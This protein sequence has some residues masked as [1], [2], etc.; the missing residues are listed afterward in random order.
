MSLFHIMQ[1]DLLLSNSQ[2]H[3]NQ[4]LFC[5]YHLHHCRNLL[6]HLATFYV[7]FIILILLKCTFQWFKKKLLL[8]LSAIRTTLLSIVHKMSRNR[9]PMN[10]NNSLLVLTR[11]ICWTWKG[12]TYLPKISRYHLSLSAKILQKSTII[13]FYHFSTRCLHERHYLPKISRYYLG[14]FSFLNGPTPASFCLFS[15]FSNTNFT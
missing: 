10:N 2:K 5:Y 3:Y 11:I 4:L 7:P 13:V 6:W 12:T 8:R 14:T 1:F 9:N 15:F